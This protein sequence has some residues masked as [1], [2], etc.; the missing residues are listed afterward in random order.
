MWRHLVSCQMNLLVRDLF[1][2]PFQSRELLQN[3][4]SWPPPRDRAWALDSLHLPQVIPLCRRVLRT[5][6]GFLR[7]INIYIYYRLLS[8]H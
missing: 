5:T 4:G 3:T 8:I 1:G 2:T 6:S 7:R